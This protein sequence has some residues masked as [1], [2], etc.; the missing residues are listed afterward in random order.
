LHSN[1]RLTKTG[2]GQKDREASCKKSGFAGG[3]F[4]PSPTHN[5]SEPGPYIPASK[6]YGWQIPNSTKVNEFS[7]ACWY[8]AQELT[9]MAAVENKTAP[10]IGLIQVVMMAAGYNDSYNDMI[11][12]R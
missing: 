3:H 7:A 2:S 6:Y 1:D 10:I 12:I 8:F 5:S 4:S 11:I 9:D